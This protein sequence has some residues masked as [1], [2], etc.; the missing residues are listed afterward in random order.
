MRESFF[1]KLFL[2]KAARTIKRA[3]CIALDLVLL[4][5]QIIIAFVQTIYSMVRDKKGFHTALTERAK[6]FVPRH[7]RRDSVLAVLKVLAAAGRAS[8]EDIRAHY[9]NNLKVWSGEKTKRDKERMLDGQGRYIEH[10]S[11]MRSIRY[12]TARPALDRLV[13]GGKASLDGSSNTCEV[14]AV[15][16]ALLALEEG[17]A[18]VSFPSL[19]AQ[20]EKKGM[21]LGGYFGTS[22]DY[23]EA[24]FQK[25]YER[26]LLS[27]ARITAHAL[28]RLSEEYAAY[29]LTAY[30]DRED[31]TK[32]IHTMCISGQMGKYQVHNG[33]QGK[34]YD[35]LGDAVFGY[36]SG[37]GRAICVIGVRKLR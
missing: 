12:G 11:Y 37:K 28:K 4:P 20:F 24:Y 17:A 33:D 14:I 15:Y 21:I 32:E 6:A 31:I 9:Q 3:G 7:I 23:I 29:I 22:P 13:F 34:V 30:N 5:F 35:S 19:L 36:K 25:E 2:R 18:A 16:N 27:G 8:E 26:K 10:Q 1:W